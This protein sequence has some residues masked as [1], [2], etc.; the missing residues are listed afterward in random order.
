MTPGTWRA[1]EDLDLGELPD[2]HLIN[3]HEAFE[4][5]GLQVQPFPVPHDAREPCQF[6]FSDGNHRV[7][8][9]TDTGSVTPHIEATLDGCDALMVECNHDLDMLLEGP[10]PEALKQRVSGPYGHLDNHTSARLI[11]GLRHD[12]LQHLVAMHLS[13]KNNM[14]EHVLAALAGQLDCDHD[15]ITLASQQ[16]GFGWRELS[17]GSV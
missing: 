2:V 9:L 11:A 14:P 16:Q 13:E 7:G 1:L 5:N 17:N 3:T 10:Y 15:W 4:I 6:V 8:L 12:G